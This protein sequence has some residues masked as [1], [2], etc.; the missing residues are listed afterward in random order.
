M[1]I[2]RFIEGNDNFCYGVMTDGA[3]RYANGDPYEGLSLTEEYRDIELV[4][5]LPPCTPSKIVAVGLNYYGHAREL[6]KSIPSNPLIFLKPSTSVIG[7]EEHIVYPSSSH[8]VDYEGELAV[9]IKTTA[10]NVPVEKALDYVLGYTCFNDVTARDI[11]K[12]DGQWTRAKGFD[13]FSAI[14]PCIENDID[15]MNAEIETLLNGEIRQKGN[16]SDLIYPVHNLVSFISDIM[17]L[18]PG[19]VIATGTTS[20]IGPMKPGDIV[21]VNISGIG[22]LRNHVTW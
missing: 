10:R 4:R 22:T 20:G 5:L 2:V 3:V 12:L 11:Q 13:T 7:P 18:L 14:G 21:E 6:E 9:V 8:Q 17:T 15:P 19:D 1:K 16:T